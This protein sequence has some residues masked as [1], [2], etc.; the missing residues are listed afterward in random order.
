[1]EGSVD[2]TQVIVAASPQEAIDAFGDG[3]DVTVVAGGTIVMPEIT[4]G[5]LRPRRALLIGRAGMAGVSQ[6]NGR[7]VIGACT[8]LADL[9][10]AVEPLGT[11][12]I[13]AIRMTVIPLIVASYRHTLTGPAV[14]CAPGVPARRGLGVGAAAGADGGRR[15]AML[16]RL[17][18]AGL[19]HDDPLHGAGRWMRAPARER[20]QA[21]EEI[22]EG[23]AADV[24]QVR[25]AVARVLFTDRLDQA[26][27]RKQR[28]L[29]G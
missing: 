10:E 28:A 23:G 22:A 12:W 6:E 2:A 18:R 29:Q 13:N 9:E 3:G 19:H 26:I 14:A 25:D 17:G 8:S 4:H 21:E 24:R 20:L 27:R 5:R 16:R 11:L 15:G 7:I 1:M